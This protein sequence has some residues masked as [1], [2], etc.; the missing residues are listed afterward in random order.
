MLGSE[1]LDRFSD[2]RCEFARRLQNEGARHTGAGA[3]FFEHCQERENKRSG[4]TCPRLGYSDHVAPLKGERNGLSLYRGGDGIACRFDGS[5]HFFAELKVF[6][7]HIPL[8]FWNHILG[9]R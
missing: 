1:S 8:N 5:Q 3:A 6:K 2:L 4:L 7:C 9:V